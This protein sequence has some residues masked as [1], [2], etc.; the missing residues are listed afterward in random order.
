M[1]WDAIKADNCGANPTELQ[2]WAQLFPISI[3]GNKLLNR[4]NIN[5]EY[6]Y[7]CKSATWFRTS[8]M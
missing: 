8:T 2:N 7:T 6:M 4:K 1:F 5:G 3:D